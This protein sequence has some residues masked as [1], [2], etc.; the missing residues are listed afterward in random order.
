MK[1]LLLLCLIALLTG[2]GLAENEN[3]DAPTFNI[4]FPNE[5]A[6]QLFLDNYRNKVKAEIQKDFD[7]TRAETGIFNPW[8]LDLT[9]EVTYK[10]PFWC[11]VMSGYDYRGGAHGIPFLDVVY[12]DGETKAEIQQEEV[13]IPGALEELASLSRAGL[14]K[15]GFDAED[16][17]MLKGTEPTAENYQVVA[18]KK[19]GLEVIFPSYQV[20]PYAAGTP[21]VMIPWSK[22]KSLIAER[23]R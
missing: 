1:R 2:A 16:E 18:A 15:Q 14:I 10:G 12:F 17:W 7:E 13:L 11:V 3:L 19:E 5:P 20:A 6:I 22:A 23:Y 21:S 9:A 8:S 4:S